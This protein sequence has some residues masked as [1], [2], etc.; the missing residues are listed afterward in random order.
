M[1]VK[2]ILGIDPG[3]NN[4]GW[5]IVKAEGNSLSFIA[6]GTIKTTTKQTTTER[7]KTIHEGF[8]ELLARYHPTTAA[9]EEV[10]V[11]ENAR[12]SLKLGQA[13][14]VAML[15]VG[16]A[17]LECAEYTPTAIKKAIVGTGRADKT[18]M[19]YMVKMLLPTA[20]PKT[21]D[22]ADALAVAIC[23]AHTSHRQF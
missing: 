6:S 17:G 21:A 15:A 2:I 23:H 22:A 1:G 16:L 7:L 4:T 5:G 11:N 19:G 3:L 13:R 9:I 8:V 14:G 10:F 20:T 12:S 18:Q